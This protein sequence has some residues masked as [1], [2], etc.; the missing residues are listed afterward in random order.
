V[1]KTVFTEGSAMCSSE[2]TTDQGTMEKWAERSDGLPSVIR[3]RGTRDVRR[4]DFGQKGERF[5]EI[6]RVGLVKVFH[7]NRSAFLCYSEAKNGETS[8]SAER[9][10]AWSGP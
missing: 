10:G 6:G 9:Q 1:I 5:E 7:E 4:V 2:P 3:T 8:C